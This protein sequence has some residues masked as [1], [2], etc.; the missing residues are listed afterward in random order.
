M[1]YKVKNT[2]INFTNYEIFQNI[3]LTIL[4]RMNY[5]VFITLYNKFWVGGGSQRNR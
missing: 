3:Y 4:R 5:D 1:E 2:P